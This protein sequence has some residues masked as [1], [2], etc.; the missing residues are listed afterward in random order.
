MQ[1]TGSS[2][3]SIWRDVFVIVTSFVV[4]F[5][6]VSKHQAESRVTVQLGVFLA[7]LGSLFFTSFTHMLNKLMLTTAI[8]LRFVKSFKL[9]LSDCVDISNK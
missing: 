2:L 3:I 4:A 5:G 6:T 1:K 7:C 8:G 9:S